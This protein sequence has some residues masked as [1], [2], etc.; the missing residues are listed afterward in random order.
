MAGK[1]GCPWSN[2]FCLQK[3]GCCRDCK[4]QCPA[5]CGV[6]VHNFDKPEIT[7]DKV[8]EPLQNE[9]K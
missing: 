2:M 4:N 6:F 1:Y 5:L 8:Y 3:C 9:I 7:Y